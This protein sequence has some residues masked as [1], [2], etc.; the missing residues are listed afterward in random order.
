MTSFLELCDASGRVVGY[1]T[2][3]DDR[4]QYE[5][6]D[7]PEDDDELDRRSREES[8]RPLDEILRDLEGR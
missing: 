3:V 5:G 6:V 1:F 4:S 2:P 7:S 8:E